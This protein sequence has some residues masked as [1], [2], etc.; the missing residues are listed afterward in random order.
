MI[1]FIVALLFSSS[2]ENLYMIHYNSDLFYDIYNT[3]NE[4]NQRKTHEISAILNYFDIYVWMI[5]KV[6]L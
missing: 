4:H 5:Q 2:E 3:I 1:E 6:F